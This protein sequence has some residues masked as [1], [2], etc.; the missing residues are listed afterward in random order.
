LR[1]KLLMFV[2][3]AAAVLTAA[4]CAE[5]PEGGAA[6]PLLCPE[7]SAALRDTIIDAVAFDTT[8][9][10]LPP[11]GAERFLMLAAHGDTLDT[12]V[13]IRFDTL[14]Q[15]FTAGNSLDSTITRLDSAV[16]VMPIVKP[17]TAHR[18][19]GRI[20]IEAYNVDSMPPDSVTI[21]TDTVASVLATLFR[22][23]RL[24]GSRTFAPESLLDTLRLPLSTDSV[25][26]RVKNGT[27]LRVGLRLVTSG[28]Q[29]YNL[30]IGS[31]QTTA[32]TSLRLKASP[33]TAAKAVVI[34]P[35]SN[36]PK[37]QD[38]LSGP[39]ADYSIVVKGGTGNVPG[40]LGVGGVPSRRTLLRFNVPSRIIDSTT[41]VRASL[42]ITQKPNRGVS[43]RDS[44]YVFPSAVLAQSTVTD[45]RNLLQFV[46]AQGTFGLDSLKLAPGDSGVRSFEIVS[47]VRTWKGNSPE[48]SPRAVA[49]RSSSEGS[50]PGQIDFFSTK[51]AVASVRPRLRIT[52]VPQTT[53]GLP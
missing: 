45:V 11:I 2:A 30:Q 38:F 23:G 51:A 10:G 32:P 8:V 46:S 31:T 40:V 3:A 27:K 25:L 28:G 18:P 33:D 37:G 19:K 49:L 13:I 1:K 47:L 6:C 44:I 24:I 53:F 15:T 22:P 50:L 4:A 26:T 41:V 7:Q 42:L 14:P 35:L 5:N 34:T 12:R 21:P 48:L 36:T 43:Q 17:D 16:L 20:T 52:Y 9:T 29:G 39:L